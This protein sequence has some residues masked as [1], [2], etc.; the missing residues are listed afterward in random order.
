M[1]KKKSVRRCQGKMKRTSLKSIAVLVAISLFIAIALA[2]VNL[3][4]APKIAEANQKAQQEALSAVLPENGGFE[5]LS[6]ADEVGMPECISAFY[7]DLDGEGYAA[8][9]SIKGYDS[10][11]PMEAAIGFTSGGAIT[12]I[13]MISVQGETTGIGTKVSNPEFLAQLNGK[14]ADSVGEVDTISGATISS[15]AFLNAVKEVI[16]VLPNK[17]AK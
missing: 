12:S 2:A 8:L 6:V 16:A 5:E 14:T 7:R 13:K 3:V 17:E 11:K 15:T 9:L 1:D 10:S 4:T